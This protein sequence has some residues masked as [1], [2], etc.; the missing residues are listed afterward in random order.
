[1]AAR[2][3]VGLVAFVLLLAA[4]LGTLPSSW[5]R[6]V[7]GNSWLLRGIIV[8]VAM[9]FS[10]W[11]RAIVYALLPRSPVLLRKRL[12]LLVK[13]RRIGIAVDRIAAVHVEQRP[14]PA[15]EV[16]VVELKDGAEYD[17]CPV[18][19]DG[20]ALLYRALRRRVR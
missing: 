8:L 7:G 15:H 11:V 4:V 20:A 9:W 5:I 14:E 1:M 19:W 13:G 6:L 10:V 18:H 3:G 12:T 17:V 16:F 2:V